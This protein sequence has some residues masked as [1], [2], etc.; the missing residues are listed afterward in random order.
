MLGRSPRLARSLRVLLTDT[1]LLGV[2]P[3]LGGLCAASTQTAPSAAAGTARGLVPPARS[4]SVIIPVHR[5]A[6]PLPSTCSPT[7]T[8]SQTASP[9]PPTGIYTQRAPPRP[10]QAWS[11]HPDATP[12][13]HSALS[14]ATGTGQHTV[15]VHTRRVHLRPPPRGTRVAQ[16][17][18]RPTVAQVMTSRFVSSSPASGSLLSACQ[19]RA[20]I[21]SSVSLSLPLSRLRSLENKQTLKKKKKTLCKRF[22]CIWGLPRVPGQSS[23]SSEYETVGTPFA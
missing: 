7:H 12:D 5:G 22:Q 16:S 11:H 2:S 4:A 20:C 13:P 18:E 10:S 3:C 1:I 21:R 15:P 14:G 8:Q 17:V 6:R 19:R 23:S 9:A